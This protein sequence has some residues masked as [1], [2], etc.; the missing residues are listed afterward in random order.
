MKKVLIVEDDDA[1]RE[2]FTIMLAGNYEVLEA[3]NG[4]KAIEIYM[5]EKPD[6]VLMDIVMPDIDGVVA[7]REILK[8]DPEAKILGVSAFTVHR[9]E[10]LLAAGAREI[11]TKPFT[12][13]KL[14]EVV[15][16]YIGD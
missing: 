9:G 10:E 11:I 13:K 6:L 2:V 12:R 8:I 5:R 3:D 4:R 14:L 15:K 7:T 1:V 16:K